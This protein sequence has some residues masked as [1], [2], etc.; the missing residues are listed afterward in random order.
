[1]FTMQ[2]T[3]D[4]RGR[5]V[6]MAMLPPPPIKPITLPWQRGFSGRGKK[7]LIRLWNSIL[8]EPGQPIA[9]LSKLIHLTACKKTKHTVSLLYR[10]IYIRWLV[11][12]YGTARTRTN[13]GWI[14][15]PPSHRGIPPPFVLIGYLI[16]CC[17]MLTYVKMISYCKMYSFVRTSE[18]LI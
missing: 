17:F 10:T 12:S 2:C 8:P 4:D 14:L 16:F 5:A 13:V 3:N 7:E 6:A 1:M 11:A 9:E 15:I 18:P